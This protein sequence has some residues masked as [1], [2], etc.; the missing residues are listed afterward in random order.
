MAKAKARAQG[1]YSLNNTRQLGV[2]CFLYTDDNRGNLPYNLGVNISG[3]GTGVNPPME[4]NWANNVEDWELSPD[5]TNAAALLATGLGPY[6]GGSAAIYRC[7]TDY[8][9]SSI[10]KQAGWNNRVRSYSMNAMVGDAGQFTQAGY[11]VNNP[12]YLQFF[13][14]SAIPRPSDIF[15][16]TEEHPDSINDGYF[17][18][19]GERPEWRDLPASDHDGAGVFSFADGHSEMHRWRRNS[20]KPPVRPGAAKLPILLKNYDLQDFLW[21]LSTMSVERKPEHYHY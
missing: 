5:N 8:V 20:T 15:I 16:F 1:V 21:V 18:N 3:K 19:S 11:N 4:L 14:Q 9:V 13:N 12:S 7:P 2:A 6:T 10:Q 17:L